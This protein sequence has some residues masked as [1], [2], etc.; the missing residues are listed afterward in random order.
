MSDR[1]RCE[2][3]AHRT[4]RGRCTNDSID[5]HSFCKRHLRSVQARTTRASG[6]GGGR[7]PYKKV[8]IVRNEF[9]HYEDKETGIVF[10][11]SSRKAIGHQSRSGGVL[12]FEERHIRQCKENGWDFVLNRGETS[13]AGGGQAENRFAEEDA[14]RDDDQTELE[15]I[16]QEEKEIQMKASKLRME[17][18][19]LEHRQQALDR[20]R[21]EFSSR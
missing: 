8:E 20:R 18:H 4:D 3:T 17:R 5:S 11:R 13:A 2:F 14:A 9:G 7:H 6:G 16:T 15:A 1:H 12:P 10:D 21:G 19:R